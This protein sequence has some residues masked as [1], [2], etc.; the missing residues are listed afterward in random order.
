MKEFFLYQRK[1]FKETTQTKILTGKDYTLK[2]S[3]SK[4][5]NI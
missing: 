2:V 1:C 4:N 3:G 5:A